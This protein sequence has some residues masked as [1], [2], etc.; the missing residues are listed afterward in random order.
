MAKEALEIKLEDAG[1][2]IA[3]KPFVI[4]Q[5]GNIINAE[6]M[7]EIWEETKVKVTRINRGSPKEIQLFSKTVEEAVSKLD[8]EEFNRLKKLIR[9]A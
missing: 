3:I 2:D 1:F 8:R 6:D 4:I 7:L 9:A 5:M